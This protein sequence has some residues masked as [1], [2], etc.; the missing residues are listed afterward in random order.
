MHH[1]CKVEPESTDHIFIVYIAGLK[2]DTQIF[3]D[4]SQ[5]VEHMLQAVLPHVKTEMAVYP[6]YQDTAVLHFVDWLVTLIVEREVSNGMD[7]RTVKVVLCGHST[8]G[9]LAAD[10]LR[11]LHRIPSTN[12]SPSWPHVI[13]CVALDTP[14]LGVHPNVIHS[15]EL[16]D[17]KSSS[18]VP[19]GA[20]TA[21]IAGPVVASG[22]VDSSVLVSGTIAG[23]VE[24]GISTGL[25]LASGLIGGLGSL[26]L[27][28]AGGLAAYQQ[29]RLRTRQLSSVTDR[30]RYFD[31]IGDQAL[32]KERFNALLKIEKEHGVLFRLIY[33]QLPPA[34][35]ASLACRTFIVVPHDGNEDSRN[36][37]PLANTV[38]AN[39]LQAHIRMLSSSTNSGYFRL[40]HMFIK[41]IEEALKMGKERVSG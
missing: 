32:Q 9:I 7:A 35:P 11:E 5:R 10:A 27:L 18:R 30:M 22:I 13:A 4:F 16:S 25:A 41:V 14:Y 29:N 19:A 2:G 24:L 15:E 40:T 39:E 1:T 17:S 36:L 21:V 28:T 8:G 12:N 23:S 38:A 34:S 37:V 6:A 3:D 31:Q 33:T 20:A 26:A